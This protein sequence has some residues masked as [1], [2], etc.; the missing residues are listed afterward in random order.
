LI[1]QDEAALTLTLAL[2]RFVQSVEL[3]HAPPRMKLQ[4]VEQDLSRIPWQ[5]M[6]NFVSKDE[7]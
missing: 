1:D 6:K 3:I 4:S 7:K 2:V 5:R